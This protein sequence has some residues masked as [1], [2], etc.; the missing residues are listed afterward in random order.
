MMTDSIPDAVR[1]P[2]TTMAS[3][4]CSVAKTSTSSGSAVGCVLMVPSFLGFQTQWRKRQLWQKTRRAID[5]KHT[6]VVSQFQIHVGHVAQPPPAVAGK[7][8]RRGRRCHTIFVKLRH[9]PHR[10]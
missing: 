7:E 9:Y 8:H 3:D 2:C 5:R 6:G 4:T 1:R 10:R